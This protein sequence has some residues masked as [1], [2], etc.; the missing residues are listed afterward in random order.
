MKF[1]LCNSVHEKSNSSISFGISCFVAF[2]KM[3]MTGND[4]GEDLKDLFIKKGFS[5]FE[6]GPIQF[7]TQFQAF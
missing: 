1:R 7:R 6:I 4:I 3:L 2:G 5:E